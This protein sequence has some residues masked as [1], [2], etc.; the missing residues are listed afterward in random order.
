MEKQ[1]KITFQ[2][3][4]QERTYT[5]RNGQQQVFASRGFV[6]SDGVDTFYA[7]AVG[8][9]ARSMPD[10]FSTTASYGVQTQLTVREFRDKEGN[11]RYQTDVRIL[12]MGGVLN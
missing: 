5:D 7:E 2:T 9:Y 8:D 12:K 3:P 10:H 6:L 4:L 1:V 11:A